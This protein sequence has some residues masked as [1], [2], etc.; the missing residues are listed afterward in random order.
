MIMQ[1][2]FGKIRLHRTALGNWQIGGNQ[3][4]GS[5]FYS[6]TA[7]RHDVYGRNNQRYAHL[8]GNQSTSPSMITLSVDLS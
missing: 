2:F 3:R 8:I 4:S 5:R 7:P 1:Q 6:N